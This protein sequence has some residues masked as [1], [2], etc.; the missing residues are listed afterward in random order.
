MRVISQFES[1]HRKPEA[2][3]LLAFAVWAVDS[4][5]YLGDLDQELDPSQ[6]M[7]GEHSADVIDV[8]HARWAV[9][10]CIT[11]LDLCA[12]ALGRVSCGHH[13]RE[14]ALSDFNLKGDVQRKQHLRAN[15]R[16]QA[17]QWID[18]VLGDTGYREIKAVRNALTHARVPR[19]FALPRQRV[20]LQVK[21]LQIDVPTIIDTAKRVGSKH[22]SEL[23]ATLPD[24]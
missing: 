6:A 12:A 9:T 16:E 10:T 21:D 22:V 17:R 23:L 5:Y 15:L 18:D 11:A 7:A 4:L 19:H 20:R 1:R 14:L 8:A 13:K 3:A 2:G 24:L